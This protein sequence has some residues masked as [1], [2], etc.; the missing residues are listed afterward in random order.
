M[1]WRRRNSKGYAGFVTLHR[2]EPDPFNAVL[3]LDRGRKG[4]M[5]L[6]L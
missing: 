2:L 5:R 4:P 1:K 6:L 3:S